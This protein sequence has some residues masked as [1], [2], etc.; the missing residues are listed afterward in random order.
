V[1]VGVLRSWGPT[2]EQSIAIAYLVV[3]G[4]HAGEGGPVPPTGKAFD[5]DTDRLEERADRRC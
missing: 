3:K 5:V 2:V 1:S 4:T